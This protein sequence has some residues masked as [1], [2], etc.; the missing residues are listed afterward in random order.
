MSESKCHWA[1][2]G[3]LF[4]IFIY[5]LDWLVWNSCVI[6]NQ[7]NPNPVISY[8]IPIFVKTFTA[9]RDIVGQWEC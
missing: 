5:W 2:Q 6:K 7:I 9:G 8:Q 3:S 4:K 1:L